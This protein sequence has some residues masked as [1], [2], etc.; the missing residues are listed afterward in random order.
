M[1]MRWTRYL[2]M[3]DSFTEGMVDPV[4]GP[5]GHAAE[6]DAHRGWADRLAERLDADAK[7]AG[8]PG[9]EYAN[10]AVRG[11]LLHQ[12]LQEQVP[13]ALAAD[14]PGAT[15]V[16]LVGGG[17]DV[18]RPRSDPDALADA[19]E[20]AVASLRHT[21]ADVLM[22]TAMD[23][24]DSP[25]IRLTRGRAAVYTAHIWAIARRHG[26]FVVDLWG[27]RAL[28]DWRMWAPDRIH[29]GPDGHARVADMAAASLGLEVDGAWAV[30]LPA[31]AR[32]PWQQSLREEAAWTRQYV[33]PWVRRRVRGQS[34]GDG[35][36]AKRPLPLP[37][38][39]AGQP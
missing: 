29:L 5:P 38:T 8:A 35:R 11:R 15:L 12:I 1:T 3:G 14:A 25:L 28:R 16:S 23:P 22:A 32:P 36:V 24:R 9:I 7:A 18:L 37:W 39:G 2:A 13:V 20:A 19:L 26:A 10:L 4:A 21:G 27:T 6:G 31:L 30:P 34:S 17:N 33:A